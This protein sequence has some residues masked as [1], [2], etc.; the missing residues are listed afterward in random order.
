LTIRASGDHGR[1]L[2]SL[3]PGTRIAIEGP[4]GAFTSEKR[5]GERVLL[6]GAGVGVTPLRAI[7]EDLP[8]HVDVT[9][10]VRASSAGDLVLHEELTCLVRTRG[11]QI[12]EV[13]GPR[14]A[15][16]FD[17][18]MLR[19]LVPDVSE[20]DVYVCGPDGFADSL[21]TA[22]RRLGVPEG[23]IHREQFAF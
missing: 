23:R 14:D 20:R 2:T 17:V 12:H 5:R 16:M 9:V 15:V 21:L 11:G 13:I 22:A 4:Y 10:I 6:V 1:S 8:S 19:T 7:L 18:R 3:T